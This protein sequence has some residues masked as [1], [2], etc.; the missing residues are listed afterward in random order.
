MSYFHSQII[1]EEKCLGTLKCIR[2]CP[3]QAIRVRNNRITL[4]DDLCVD[5]G[6]C[7]KACPE[8]VFIPIT[9]QLYDF[10]KF[11]FKIAIP[12]RI[13][14]TQFD[15]SIHPKIIHQALRK[16]GFDAVVDIS[17]ESHEIA[18]I[19]SDYLKNNKFPK[20]MISLFCPS[21]IRLIQ[22]KYPNLSELISPFEVPRELI[23]KEAKKKYSKEYGI[24]MSEIGVIY[25]IPCPAIAVSIK[26]PAEKEKSWIDG[27]IAIKDIYNM[28]LPEI[29]RLKETYKP[30]KKRD[31]FYYGRGWGILGSSQQ[32]LDTERCMTVNGMD[33]VKMVLDDIEDLK[34]KNI[35][36]IDA[37]TCTKGC[38]GGAFCVENPYI[39]RHNSY[40]L[41]KR[42]G[43]P[44]DFDKDNVLKK[45]R[46]KYYFS[47]YQVYPRTRHIDTD[48]ATS[49][50]RAKQKER[51]YLKL[52]KKDCGLCG[53]PNCMTFAQDCAC[54]E[55]DLSE[56]IFFKLKSF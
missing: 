29:L 4:Y 8:K 54:G 26:Q 18:Y 6:E 28:I 10:D 14:Y 42:F 22:V 46:E 48:L 40:L 55:A 19:I 15:Q 52:P 56:C 44:V 37:F 20:P 41:E 35:D 1:L 9:D 2:A 45:Y 43:A 30:K 33:N 32:Y 21:L 49:I 7:I 51:I 36:Y 50:K 13:L 23:A 12:S 16:I 17:Q 5:C 38:I 47:E 24:D 39:A 27:A 53:A 31:F 3:T 25:I 11:K 34:L